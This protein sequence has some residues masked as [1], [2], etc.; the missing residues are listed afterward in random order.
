MSFF[1]IWKFFLLT[2][3]CALHSF[4]QARF[5]DHLRTCE[6][7][8]EGEQVKGIDFIYLINLD[9]RP[10]RLKN[11]LE[12]LAPYKIV[13]YRFPA[14]IG[15]EL[16]AEALNDLGLSFQEG[17][18]ED[19]WVN[20]FP[21]EG[22]GHMEREFLCQRC[23]GKTVFSK[24]MR[25]GAIGC[26]LSHLSV[27]QD[28]YDSGYETVWVLEDD[29]CVKREPHYI[30]TLI[31][32]LDALV[33]KDNWDVLYT[34]QDREFDSER[35]LDSVLWYIFRPDVGPSNQAFLRKRDVVSEDFVKLGSRWRTHSMI[36][37][38]SGMRK[39][40]AFEKKHHMFIPYDHEIALVDDIR[41]YM[42]RYPVV[43]C[44]NSR[45]D[46]QNCE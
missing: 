14:V 6:N 40:L 43:T 5:E 15:K 34:D 8:V 45:S 37:R 46:I 22:K 10:D 19:Y 30:S 24:Y 18:E 25:K 32:R 4:C 41:L 28:A 26:T 39:I 20:H 11:S 16:S 36:I 44:G 33:G 29:I 12:G 3:F 9:F 27:L 42:T 7:K 31:E 17:M 38:R 23:Y 21:V 35:D 1:R 2:I 13:P